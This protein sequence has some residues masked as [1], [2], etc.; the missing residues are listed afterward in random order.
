VLLVSPPLRASLSRFLRHHLP[1]MGVLSNV[2]IPDERIVRVT[3]VIG[4]TAS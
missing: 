2:E 1:Q 4:G 3:A